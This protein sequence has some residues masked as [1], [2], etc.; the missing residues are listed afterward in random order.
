VSVPLLVLMLTAMITAMTLSLR[1]HAAHAA[2]VDLADL[3]AQHAATTTLDGCLT[4]AGCASPASS[5][6]TV[7]AAG[8]AGLRA[9]STVSWSATLWKNLTPVN[10]THVIAYDTGIDDDQLPSLISGSLN[11]C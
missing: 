8:D 4:A 3:H 7:C 11:A 1:D 5:H 2:A 6:A 10:A 9:T